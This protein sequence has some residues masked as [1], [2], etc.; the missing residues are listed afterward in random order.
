[1][2]LPG[3]SKPAFLQSCNVICSHYMSVHVHVHAHIYVHKSFPINNIS[4]ITLNFNI[5]SSR[6]N[7]IKNFPNKVYGYSI[8]PIFLF[9]VVDVIAFA[10][11]RLKRGCKVDR[12]GTMEYEVSWSK[13]C[14]SV[15]EV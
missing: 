11:S 14:I 12:N 4:P 10:S 13:V 6:E 2:P 1:M 5:Q 9:L 3:F 7:P 8:F 15:Q